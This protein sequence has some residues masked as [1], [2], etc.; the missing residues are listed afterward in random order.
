MKSIRF[1][2]RSLALA[3]C[4]AS[5]LPLAAQTTSGS[6]TTSTSSRRSSGFDWGWLGL[7]GLAGLLGTRRKNNVHDVTLPRPTSGR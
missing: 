4:L 2:T 1:A 6:D 3:V 5:A 7:V